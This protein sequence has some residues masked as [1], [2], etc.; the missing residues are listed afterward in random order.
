M[1]LKLL[2]KSQDPDEAQ[3][4]QNL[5]KLTAHALEEVRQVALELRPKILDDWGLEAALGWRVDELSKACSVRANLQVIGMRNR[6][7]RDLELTFYRVAQ[8]AI[9]NIARHSRARHAHIAL[10]RE[11]HCLTLEIKDD[12]VGF[13]TTAMQAGRLQGYGLLGMRERMAL[14]G[15]EFV[16]ESQP[17]KGT[18]LVARAPLASLIVDGELDEKDSGAASG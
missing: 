5:R 10:K 16:I 1:Y 2:E 9:N 4:I 18:R 8:E 15:G 17:G 11:G 3:R 7:P 12:G 6:L 14:V 13:N